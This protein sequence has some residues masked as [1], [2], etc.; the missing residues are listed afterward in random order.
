MPDPKHLRILEKG[1]KA[2]NDW[3]EKN[4]FIF[5]NFVKANLSGADLSGANLSRAHLSEA[6]LSEADLSG[7]NL[8]G[9]NLRRADLSKA[10]LKQAHLRDARLSWANLKGVNLSRSDLIR[11]NI[12]GVNLSGAVLREVDLRATHLGSANLIGTDLSGANLR[13]A[14]LRRAD[15]S[16]VC[17]TK[18]QLNRA[19][20]SEAHLFEADLSGVNLRYADLRGAQLNRANLRMANLLRASLRRANLREA[21]LKMAILRKADLSGA[22]LRGADLRDTDLRQATFEN[23]IVSSRTVLTLLRFALTDEQEAA[24]I[25]SDEREIAKK[26]NSSKKLKNYQYL[27]IE[28]QD[29]ISWK[30]EWL[31]FLL[32]SIQTTYNNCFYICSTEDKDIKIIQKKLERKCQVS[33]KNDIELKIIQQ[34]SQLSILY[35]QYSMENEPQVATALST[36]AALINAI[37]KSYKTIAD[38]RNFALAFQQTDYIAEVMEILQKD[39]EQISIPTSN[40]VILRNTGKLLLLASKTL[41]F[42]LGTIKETA[43]IGEILVKMRKS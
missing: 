39:L 21:Q 19:N 30:N 17:F 7:A 41:I 23:T 4:P 42:V 9:A 33:A 29:E 3:R 24:I 34:R 5:A 35:A 27:K 32:L 1:V 37:E 18:A 40:K 10:D 28:F 13:G 16:W 22:D 36:L 6:N 14:W 38:G 25:F 26:K 8:R 43:N 12:T 15:L 2:F 11:A 20:L 31:A